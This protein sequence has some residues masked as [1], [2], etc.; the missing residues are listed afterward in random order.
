[1]SY[2]EIAKK[3]RIT[4][5]VVQ[6]II[7]TRG[8]QKKKTGPKPKISKIDI[9][10]IRNEI[11]SSFNEN[12]KCTI[13]D[14]IKN[15]DMK[16]S[17]STVWRSLRTINFNYRNIPTKFALSTKAKRKRVELAKKFIISNVQWSNVIFSDEKLFTLHGVD[18]HYCWIHDGYSPR[19][20]KRLI[21]APGIMV[22]AMVLPNGLISYAIMR[23]RQNSK[24][25][26]KI[27]RRAIY[28]MKLS[29]KEEFI[30]Q[31]DNCPLHVS[32]YSRNF[33]TQENI[34]LLEWPPYSPDLNI[35]ENVWPILANYIYY[36]PTIK[37]LK[38]LTSRI[39]NAFRRFNE[40][41][42]NTVNNL[43]RSIKERLVTVISRRGDRINY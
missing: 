18:S 20:I 34:K 32:K 22:W 26:T 14:L 4:R 25:Y 36:G 23:G 24:T 12:R 1:M 15:L 41:K 29:F 31:Q 3:Y 8:N 33:F 9:R 30:F 17:R 19:R 28:I 37:N 5:S 27:I 42:F 10:H 6:Y 16:V 11:S 21:R 40:E 35:I 43:Y 13:S 7:R 39:D 2:G 38:E